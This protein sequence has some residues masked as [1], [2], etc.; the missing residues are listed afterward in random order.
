M[1]LRSPRMLET[2]TVATTGPTKVTGGLMT[3]LNPSPLRLMNDGSIGPEVTLMATSVGSVN[4]CTRLT[5]LAR[6]LGTVT[7]VKADAT[8]EVD[9]VVSNEVVLLGSNVGAGVVDRSLLE[10]VP[11]VPLCEDSI[12]LV[13]V[14]ETGARLSVE[15][16][17]TGARLSE[18]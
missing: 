16:E 9:D 10:G 11:V 4:N 15:V 5:M 7:S 18:I 1:V 3:K 2:V 17:E 12:V 13:E 6:V 14:E 8:D